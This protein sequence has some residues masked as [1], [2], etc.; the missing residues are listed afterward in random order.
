MTRG[1]TGNEATPVAGEAFV[2]PEMR[3]RFEAD[4]RAVRDADWRECVSRIIGDAMRATG[5]N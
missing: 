3:A 2:K 5:G 4:Q 1:A